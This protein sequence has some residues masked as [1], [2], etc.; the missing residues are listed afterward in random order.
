MF[1]VEI[2]GQASNS[3]IKTIIVTQAD[4]KKTILELLQEHKIPVASSCMGEGICEK[5]IINDS[6]LGCLKLVSA[7][8]SWQ[9]KVITIAYL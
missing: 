7:I 8:E 1:E 3:T 2:R 4:L 9:S 5:C 6:V